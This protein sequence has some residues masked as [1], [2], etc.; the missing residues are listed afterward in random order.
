MK[1]IKIVK[2]DIRTLGR[3]ADLLYAMREARL[4]K[5]REVDDMKSKE[6]ALEQK[7]LDTLEENDLQRA[8]GHVATASKTTSTVPQVEDWAKVRAYIKKND[9]FELLHQRIASRAWGELH[10]AGKKVPG[11]E[12]VVKFDLSLTKASK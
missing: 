4:A 7:I 1:V 11:I 2:P 10:D 12:A 9:A 5:A 3:M 6:R 8:S